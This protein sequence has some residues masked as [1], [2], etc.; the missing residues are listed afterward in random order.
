[1]A[2]ASQP[3][4]GQARHCVWL[5]PVRLLLRLY[6]RIRYHSF[7]DNRFA[8]AAVCAPTLARRAL[9]L[10]SP[11]AIG[12]EQPCTAT[13]TTSVLRHCFALF[14]ASSLLPF[15]PDKLHFTPLSKLCPSA[16]ARPSVRSFRRKT[17]S[18]VRGCCHSASV[19]RAPFEGAPHADIQAWFPSTDCIGPACYATLVQIKSS[20][21][22]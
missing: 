1:M 15:P 14:F 21:L 3:R 13:A 22:P 4:P 20:L 2:E 16:T 11:L 9:P 17:L 10:H 8:H 5:C 7:S 12:P 19:W 6:S 18:V